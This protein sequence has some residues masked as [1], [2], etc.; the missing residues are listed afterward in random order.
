MPEPTTAIGLIAMIVTLLISN[1]GMWIREWKKH[2]TWQKNGKGINE[3]NKCVKTI[4]G[5]MD[6]ANVEIGKVQTSIDDQKAFC[7]KVSGGLS[8]LVAKNS[9][10]I[11]ELN[12]DKNA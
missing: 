9:D 12:K 2:S 8:E 7:K 6:K 4:D 1:I 3:V 11:F 10:R 5:K